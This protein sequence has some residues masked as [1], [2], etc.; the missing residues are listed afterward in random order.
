[1][2]E[3]LQKSRQDEIITKI[4]SSVNLKLNQ[5]MSSIKEVKEE[6]SQ[7]SSSVKG[8]NRENEEVVTKVLPD[9]VE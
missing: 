6:M 5:A 7:V 9:I 3:E 1:L 2:Q 8:E 4:Q